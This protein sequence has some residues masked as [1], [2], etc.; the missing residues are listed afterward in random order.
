MSLYILDFITKNLGMGFEDLILFGTIISSIVLGIKDM[1]IAL[2]CAAILLAG[3]FIIF[4][5]NGMNYFKPL[6]M[7][8]IALVM[9]A[10]SLLIGYSKSQRWVV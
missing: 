10:I 2:V 4:Y 6:I 9:L 5:E 7:F 3:E 8:F 1:R